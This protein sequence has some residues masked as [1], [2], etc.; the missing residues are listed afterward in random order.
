VSGYS[1]QEL[2]SWAKRIRDWSRRGLDAYIYFDND[3]KVYAPRDA[4]NLADKVRG[5]LA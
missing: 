5:L 2:E 4:R 1:D 3:A